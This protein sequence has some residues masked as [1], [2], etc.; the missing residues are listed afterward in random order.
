MDYFKRITLHRHLLFIFI[1]VLTNNLF[2]Q[3]EK[4]ASKTTIPIDT[5]INI[6]VTQLD[7]NELDC[8]NVYY[9]KYQ[10]KKARFIVDK[11]K[12]IFKTQIPKTI[13]L[14]GIY[15]FCIL[16]RQT[17]KRI[18]YQ[19]GCYMNGFGVPRHQQTMTDPN[20]TYYNFDEESEFP[21]L[22]LCDKK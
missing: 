18:Y 6:T 16:D 8:Y 19:R 1:F 20:I 17:G 2:G 13:R 12:D 15:N 4:L 9:F 22:R 3:S 5:L 11:T 21:T 7:T 10:D 14:C